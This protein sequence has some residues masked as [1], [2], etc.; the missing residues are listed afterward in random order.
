MRA[1]REALSREGRERER[2]DGEVGPEGVRGWGRRGAHSG[3]EGK[4]LI[5]NDVLPIPIWSQA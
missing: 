5:C 4:T 3:L 2:E 1:G